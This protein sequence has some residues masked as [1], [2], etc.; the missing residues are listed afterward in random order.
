MAKNKVFDGVT[1]YPAS[2]E[3]KTEKEFIDHE[4]HHGF[5]DDAMKEIYSRLTAK[6][7][8]KPAP[9]KPIPAKK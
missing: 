7:E 9:A 3:G 1:F 5:P 8:A 2:V 6:E 4:A